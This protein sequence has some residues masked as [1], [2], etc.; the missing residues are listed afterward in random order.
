VHDRGGYSV[1]FMFFPLAA[2]LRM[3]GIVSWLHLFWAGMIPV[4]ASMMGG[5]PWLLH[6]DSWCRWLS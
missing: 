3:I 6:G 5:C 1:E 4:A 2:A